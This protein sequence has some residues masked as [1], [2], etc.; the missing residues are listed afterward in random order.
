MKIG[1]FGANGPTGRLVVRRALEEGHEVTAFTRHP[2]SFS[3][4]SELLRV[5]GGDVA[6]PAAVESAITGQDAVLSSLGTPYSR[7]PITVYSQGATNIMRAMGRTGV[8]RL[9]VVSSS[10]V[11]DN[12]EEVGSLF[13]RKV[14]QPLVV[15]L[16]GKTLY[17]D[18]RRMEAL[19]KASSVDWTIVRPSGLFSSSAGSNYKVTERYGR[20]HFTAREDLADCLLREAGSGGHHR[21]VIAVVT[22]ENTPSIFSIIWNEGIRKKR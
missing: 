16:L 12:P 21:Q 3:I 19:V 20:G 1:V 18:Q 9:V 13:F 2:E 4:R 10:A 17:E 5:A 14:T 11:E 22:T 6:D 15:N 7:K 8:D